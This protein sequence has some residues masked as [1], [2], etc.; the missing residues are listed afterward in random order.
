M[1][2][3]IPLSPSIAYFSMEIGLEESMP[4][5]AGGLGVLAGDSLRAAAD[6]G[7]PLCAV[8]LLHR[9]GYFRQVLSKAGDQSE[10]PS[11]WRPEERLEELA[12]RVSV[13][14]EG[15]E[16][17]VRLWRYDVTGSGGLTLP[18][19]LLD[20]ALEENAAQDRALTDNLYGGDAR[21][22]LSQEVLLGLGGVAALRALG[23]RNIRTYHMNEA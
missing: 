18:V 9:K 6:L 11:L 1:T 14:I 10:E 15:R 8:T 13:E 20:S 4:T 22:R 7:L 21:Y 3:Q 19:Y 16:V 17:A 2:S 12:L 23:H 5:Y